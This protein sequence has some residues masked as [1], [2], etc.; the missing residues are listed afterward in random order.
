MVVR[1]PVRGPDWVEYVHRAEAVVRRAEAADWN[2][3]DVPELFAHESRADVIAK[4]IAFIHDGYRQTIIGHL[5]MA[6]IGSRFNLLGSLQP[7]AEFKIK[8]NT[9]LADLGTLF[10]ERDVAEYLYRTQY[11]K[12]AEVEY[13]NHTIFYTL[14]E[15]IFWL[16]LHG[17]GAFPSSL[18][19]MKRHFATGKII[20]N[21]VYETPF[22][23]GKKAPAVMHAQHLMLSHETPV[24]EWMEK[25]LYGGLEENTFHVEYLLTP[26]E[27]KSAHPYLTVVDEG[28]ME[29]GGVRWNVRK[30]MGT[31]PKE[32]LRGPKVPQ[33][34]EKF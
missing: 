23:D 18:E 1:S 26:T 11:S 15:L 14:R 28:R 8:P 3:G 30:F 31:T 20:Q 12:P 24:V 29:Y 2:F 34:G 13:F 25:P 17:S 4:E 27:S 5:F 9:L 19:H 32:A 33:E 10:G 7:D 6:G 22:T 16:L 21:N